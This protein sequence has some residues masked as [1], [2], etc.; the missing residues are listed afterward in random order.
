MARGTAPSICIAT[1]CATVAELV[2][3]FH[4]FC[5]DNALFVATSEPSPIGTEAPFAIL[6]ADRT[7]AIRGWCI[8]LEVLDSPHNPYQRP[9]VRL[10]MQQLTAES[11]R[12][13]AQLRAAHAAVPRAIGTAQSAPV[14]MPG[15]ASI[16]AR[17]AAIPEPTAPLRDLAPPPPAILVTHAA[18]HRRRV[19][20]PTERLPAVVLE[21]PSARRLR[22]TRPTVP[23]RPQRPLPSL[24][25]TAAARTPGSDLVLPANPLAALT[26]ASIAGMIDGE[27]VER[28]SF[29]DGT[30]APGPAPSPEP[31]PAPAPAPEPAAAN[32]PEPQLSPLPAPVPIAPP[33]A[34]R[35][36]VV[37]ALATLTAALGV[38]AVL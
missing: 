19:S 10:G 17:I 28:P 13:F 34:W 3:R 36:V 20:A 14:A 12:V 30:P 7:P 15:T 33:I 22:P 25:D 2:E 27:L 23:S 35:I 21:R 6:L 11:K 18:E 4:R 5:D 26:D 37:A 16:T 38:L 1:R 9:G 24:A 31:E 32:I 8:V 29:S